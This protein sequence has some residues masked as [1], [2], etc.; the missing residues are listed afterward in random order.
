MARTAL[1]KSDGSGS[2]EQIAVLEAALC[3]LDAS[4]VEALTADREFISVPWLK[5]L[6]AASI[7]FVI[8]LRSGRR[9][10][11]ANAPVLQTKALMR[12]APR[13]RQRCTPEA[14]PSGR[15]GS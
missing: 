13:F 8:R 15:A 11:L 9:P 7:P 4:D 12:L 3:A 1:P 14:L 6:Q 5:R 2:E 10:R